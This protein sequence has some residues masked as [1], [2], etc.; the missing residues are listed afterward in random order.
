MS[1]KNVLLLLLIKEVQHTD[2]DFCDPTGQ[3]ALGT[4]L[5]EPQH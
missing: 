1:R 5:L 4:E 3:S 2:N